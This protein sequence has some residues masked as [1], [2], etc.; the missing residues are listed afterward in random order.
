M[1]EVLKVI[2]SRRSIRSYREDQISQESPDFQ[3]TYHAPTLIIVSGRHESMGWEADC[4]AALGYK[5]ND[6][7]QTAP[8]RNLDIV[9]YIR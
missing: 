6:A 2:K 7:P 8:K 5:S 3:L 1:N 9:N 4:A